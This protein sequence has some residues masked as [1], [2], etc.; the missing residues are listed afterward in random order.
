LGTKSEVASEKK[1]NF[2]TNSAYR[3]NGRGGRRARYEGVYTGDL[4][5]KG[6]RSGGCRVDVIGG[7]RLGVFF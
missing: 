7:N 1:R 6:A 4:E 5:G 2:A 3:K